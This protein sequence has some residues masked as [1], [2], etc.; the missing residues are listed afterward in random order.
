MKLLTIII[1]CILL[2]FLIG[3]IIYQIKE[4]YRPE[5]EDPILLSVK[6]KM[7]L[8]YPQIDHLEFY[9]ANKSYT[10]NKKKVHLCLKDEKGDYYHE[11]MLLYVGLHELAH[12]KCDEIGHTDKFHKIFQQLLDKAA[13]IGI[14]DPSIPIVQNYCGHH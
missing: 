5:S 9:E 3:T 2:G 11:N 13:D 14:Y 7:R 4:E 10:T 1:I 8:I 12:V 6:E